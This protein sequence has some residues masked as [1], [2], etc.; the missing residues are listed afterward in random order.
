ML[1]P[2]GIFV[3]R[4]PWNKGKLVGQKAPLKLRDIWAIR[5]RL[6]LADR[7]RELALFNLAL[8]SKLRGCDLVQLRVRDVAHGDRIAA[9]A[10]VMQPKTQRSVQF[11][12][13]PT[14]KSVFAWIRHAALRTENYLF[15]NWLRLSPH[16]S[17]RQYA[18][19]VGLGLSISARM[20]T[21]TV[22]T[23]CAAR[24]PP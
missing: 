19:I 15:P 12:I 14:R 11:E 18:R 6:E 2:T 21:R 3:R 22:R 4:D 10:S 23:P 17:T 1:A 5:V 13:T 16:L 7:K 24:K 9:R 8:D 20:L